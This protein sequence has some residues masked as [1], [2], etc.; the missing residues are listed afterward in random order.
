MG[1]DWNPGPKAKSGFDQEFQE[2]WRKLH[3]KSCFFR[4][5]KKKRFLEITS[6]AFETLDTPRVGFDPAATEWARKAFPDR[7]DKSLTE[8][9]F[10]DRMRGFYVLELVPPCDGLPL[11]TNGQPSGYVEQY[12]FRA[13]FLTLDC[14]E[15]VGESLI[16]SAYV[17]K[18]PAETIEYGE[19]L[20]AQA[21]RF[22]AAHSIDLAQ[23]QANDDEASTE[24]KL[25][26]V[27]AAGKWCR[28]WGRKGHWLEAYF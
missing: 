22:A 6:T 16:E 27:Q 28:F 19:L 10:L 4:E 17:S 11:Y 24:N 25:H 18:L 13:Q 9:V 20:L 26:I 12:S 3:A 21:Q 23:V 1:L 8:Q 7:K 15:V 14:K 5:R 2:L